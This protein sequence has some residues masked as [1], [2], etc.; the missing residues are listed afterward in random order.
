[1]PL[2]FYKKIALTIDGLIRSKGK[3]LNGCKY[4]EIIILF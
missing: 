2:E 3:F 4:H 1:M